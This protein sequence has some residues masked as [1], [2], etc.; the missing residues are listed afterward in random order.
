[1]VVLIWLQ[2]II[3]VLLLGIIKVSNNLI[4]NNEKKN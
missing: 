2:L 4:K 3:V 1:M